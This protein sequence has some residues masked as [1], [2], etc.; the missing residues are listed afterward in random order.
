MTKIIEPTL[1]VRFTMHGAEFEVSFVSRGRVRYSSSAGGAVHHMEY[2]AFLDLQA[3]GTLIPAE[4]SVR[5][6]TAHNSQI[7]VRKHRYVQAAILN[8]T[9]PTARSALRS[10]I[11]TVSNEI[12]DSSPPSVR[13]V[14]YWILSFRLNG[15]A[16]LAP[17][18]RIGNR[19]MRFG[20]ELEHLVTEAINS[21]FLKRERSDSKA[22]QAYI[23]GR[24]PDLGIGVPNNADLVSTRT[25]QR[26]FRQLDPHLVAHAQNGSLA[27]SKIARAAG[28][29]VKAVK[30][31]SLVQMDTHI[32]DV[33]VVDPDT[34]EVQGRPRLTVILDVNTRCIVGF[35]L[36]LYN[37]NASTSL[38][39]LKDMVVRYGIPA[40]IVPD[41][42]VEFANSAFILFCAA[43]AIT[44][45]PAQK[46]DPNG[47]AHLE[48][49][50]GTLTAALI[51]TLSG[52][53]FSNPAKRGDYNSTKKARFTLDQVKSFTEEWISEIY[54]KTVHTRTMRAPGMAWDEQEKAFPPM[55]LSSEEADAL[56]RRPYQRTIQGGRVQYDRLQFYSHALATLEAKGYS[57][58]TILVN[59]LDLHTV[60]IE[61]PT[62]K[63]ELIMAES[64]DP[65]Y[66][67]GLTQYA[68][69]E[70][71][72]IV[73]E[74]AESDRRKFGRNHLTAARWELMKRIQTE[75]EVAKKW[76]RKLTNGKG[77]EK[78][79][80]DH[81][82]K[83]E[84][85][86]SFVE[87]DNVVAVSSP[88][89]VAIPTSLPNSRSENWAS[90]AK[91]NSFDVE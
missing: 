80:K 18:R 17:R 22:V 57:T 51:Q 9:R 43:L 76:L 82:E 53:T 55:K 46:Y 3:T 83:I 16:G 2:R 88:P 58:V 62:K 40:L 42:G 61:D 27:A 13:S 35:Y 64:I 56:A 52:T 68:H 75:S 50:F 72:K 32:V 54:H 8:L 41:N 48:S 12:S 73:N 81:K 69:E 21:E 23:A 90:V 30:I 38:A 34:G 59:E 89:L 85:H 84:S 6:I 65:A 37:A 71:K 4:S 7:V 63:G 86:L 14:S 67:E 77:R 44:I 19:T 5:L 78:V 66:T 36:G 25:I 70:A 15:L 49:F 28:K 29:S 60:F 87:I 47:K 11:N 33:H 74:M 20:I 1:G 31:L 39:A 10:I 79:T 24:A 91:F 26:R 45:S